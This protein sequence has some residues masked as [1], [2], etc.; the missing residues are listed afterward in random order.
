MQN[1]WK[2]G[3]NETSYTQF[4]VTS[5]AV[6]ITQ[7]HTQ[8]SSQYAHMCAHANGINLSDSAV[9]PDKHEISYVSRGKKVERP[10]GQHMRHT[11]ANNNRRP[12]DKIEMNPIRS[13]AENIVSVGF[14]V[15]RA[16]NEQKTDRDTDREREREWE[17]KNGL[18][19]NQSYSSYTSLLPFATRSI[20]SDTYT[21][22]PEQEQNCSV[23]WRK[24]Q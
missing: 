21:H 20:A 6:K 13:K 24:M 9:W 19:I 14:W 15:W 1:K 8:T 17:Y 4:S 11:Y 23:A 18:P 2:N 12:S 7:T 16:H 10:N 3:H 5:H 22:Q